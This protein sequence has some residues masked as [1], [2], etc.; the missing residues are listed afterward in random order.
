VSLH[1][2]KRVDGKL[3]QP[4]QMTQYSS[5]MGTEHFFDMQIELIRR[6]PTMKAEYFEEQWNFPTVFVLAGRN[7]STIFRQLSDE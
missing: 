3:R 4:D 7:F 5:I 1:T 6:V 2:V